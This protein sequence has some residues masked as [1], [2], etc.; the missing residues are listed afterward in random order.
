MEERK[1]RSLGK[2]GLMQKS[3]RVCEHHPGEDGILKEHL[4]LGKCPARPQEEGGVNADT[5]GGLCGLQRMPGP[6]ARNKPWG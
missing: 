3:K 6:Q 2:I 5:D 4:L 1:E